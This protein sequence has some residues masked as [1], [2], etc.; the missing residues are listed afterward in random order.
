VER[1]TVAATLTDCESITAATGFGDVPIVRRIRRRS[2]SRMRLK[3]PAADQRTK[4]PNTVL[5]GG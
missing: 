1:G 3:T 5:K 2:W 4:K